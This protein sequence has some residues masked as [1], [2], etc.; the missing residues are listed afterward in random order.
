MPQPRFVRPVALLLLASIHLAPAAFAG[1]LRPDRHAAEKKEMGSL[2]AA[3]VS[4]W[5]GIAALWEKEGSSL[6]PFGQPKPEGSSLDPFGNP[7][8]SGPR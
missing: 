7:V 3:L 2:R 8:P 1:E 5:S 6:D 4:L